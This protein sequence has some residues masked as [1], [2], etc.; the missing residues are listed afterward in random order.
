MV[1][2]V[3]TDPIIRTIRL[4][5]RASKIETVKFMALPIN[6]TNLFGM[7]YPMRIC[8]LRCVDHSK[9]IV[10]LGSILFSTTFG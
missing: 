3:A 2:G 8:A 6:A 7:V 5:T 10:Y 1:N 4:H 9:D